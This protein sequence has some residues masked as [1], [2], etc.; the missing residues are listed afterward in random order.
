LSSPIDFRDQLFWGKAILEEGELIAL[1]PL[2][3]HSLDVAAVF[4]ALTEIETFRFRLEQAADR[5][6]E[7]GQ[8]DRL[9]VICLLHDLGKTNLGFQKKIFDG[10]RNQV[11]HIGPLSGLFVHYSQEL[12]EAL[13]IDSLQ[14]WF[15]RDEVLESFLVAAWSH[16]GEPITIDSSERIGKNADK[17]WWQSDCRKNPFSEIANLMSLAKNAFPLAFQEGISPL[18]GTSQ[19]QHRFAGLVMLADWLGSHR[20]YFPVIDREP[21]FNP[22]ATGKRILIRTG[23]DVSVARAAIATAPKDFLSR[24]G[25]SDM[26][27]L[28]QIIAD[29]STGG[30]ND[31]LLIAEAET[32]SGKTEAALNRFLDLFA[33]DKVDSLYFALPTRVAAR[34]L[35]DRVCACID[36]LIPC[37][38]ERPPVVLAVPGYAKVDGIKVESLLPDFST[39][40]LDSVTE[41]YRERSW[42]AENPKRFLAAPIAVGTIDQAL[43]SSVRVKHAHLR[44]VC[45][46]RSLLVIDEVHASDVYMRQLLR[47]LLSHHL[48]L[49]GHALLLSATLGAVARSEFIAGLNKPQLPSFEQAVSTPYP[50]ITNGSGL[51][52]PAISVSGERS[53]K[54]V[55]LEVSMTMESSDAILPTIKTALS[56]GCR[57]L[58][59]LNT[60]K[61]A[62]SLFKQAEIEQGIGPEVLFKCNGVPAPH[63]GRFA[64][65]DREHLDGAVSRRLGKNSAPGPI[66]LIG[67]QTLEQSLDI[68]AD[69]LITDLCPIDVLLQRIGRLH[70]H[71]RKRPFGYERP[72]CIVL[73]PDSFSLE[74]LLRDDGKPQS[75]SK[76]LGLGSVY[77]DMRILELTLQIIRQNSLIHIP[78]Q[79][80]YLVEAATHP[81]R[82]NSFISD[83]MMRHSMLIEGG[84]LAD[85]TT[86]NFASVV[87]LYNKEFNQFRFNELDNAEYRTRLGL[88]ALQISIDGTVKSPFGFIIDEIFIPGYL[89]PR[90]LQLTN[91]IALV[92]SIC[93]TSICFTVGEKSYLYSRFG[94]ELTDA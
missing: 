86:A 7:E 73:A 38:E 84:A 71:K 15:E 75:K 3:D 92:K 54:E 11:G 47:F 68:D 19:L 22:F 36:R 62:V 48:S 37:P 91:G 94:L 43:L 46:D 87:E 21:E 82:L 20:D 32:G 23:L 31:R 66:L 51:T 6:L 72:R 55:E 58:V 49:K 14:K 1:L 56:A 59:I 17:R 13:E 25:F 16:H 83:R 53:S 42:A 63:H 81:E 12:A 41:G 26:Q 65:K 89:A 78:D 28:Q 8:L 60:V 67:T 39:R 61:R 9:S 52:K 74:Q 76:S 90:E 40:T 5:S 4:R 70:R 88:D 57:I 69:L 50:S 30:E 45:L 34:E 64:P 80:R 35:Y 24:F 44:S 33:A 18:P 2:R 79:N 93:D 10:N 85:K 29:I 27:P 77:E